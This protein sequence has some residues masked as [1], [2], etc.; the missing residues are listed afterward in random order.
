VPRIG[1]LESRGYDSQSKDSPLA[2]D[3]L[4]V[5]LGT[6]KK[7]R[8]GLKLPVAAPQLVAGLLGLS[9]IVV[10]LWTL[11]SDDPLGGEPIAVVA[12]RA[13][14]PATA[15]DE[16]AAAQGSATSNV[17]GNERPSRYDGPG[18]NAMAAARPDEAV[19]AVPGGK[20]VTII[21][22][23]SGA[24][25]NVVIPGKS[26]PKLQKVMPEA[27]LLEK[28]RH[29][30]LPK[31]AADGARP[32]AIYAHP[33]KLPP[34]KTDAPRIA[35]IVGGLGISTTATAEAI[36]KLPAAVTLAFAPY[37]PDVEQLAT[38][39]RAQDHEVLLQAPM[40]P[41][42]FPDNDP[43]PQTLLTTL[44]GEQ[45]VDRLQWLMGRMQG[46]VGVTN[47]MGAR[48]TASE[49][50]LGPVL[51]ETAKRGLIFVDDGSSARSVAGQIAGSHNL[52]FAKT[53]IVIDTVPSAV[54]IDRALARLEMTARDKGTAIGFA[55]AFPGTVARI[56]AWAKKLES[57]GFVLVPIS[58]VAVKAKSS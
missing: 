51:R 42:D 11:F 55:T 38:R 22:G 9:V 57:R 49:Q 7:K 4:D 18:A 45:N 10:G 14:S 25:K 1:V 39:A 2:A 16:N 40:E 17:N 58:M 32:S 23:M 30:M 8:P 46:Y 27:R 34:D 44:S 35:I 43:G 47:Y 52:P 50:A 31:I 5:P 54:E 33:V 24:T 20:T 15:K 28:S 29:G 3:D 12:T 37:G 48:F 19:A 13:T 53:D 21:D 36:E 56:A 26:D 6:D 41:F